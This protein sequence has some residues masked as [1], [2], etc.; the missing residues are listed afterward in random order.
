MDIIEYCEELLENIN[1]DS[2]DSNNNNVSLSNGHASLVDDVSSMF[3]DKT[4]VSAPVT[5]SREEVK[6]SLGEKYH[7]IVQLVQDR[8]ESQLGTSVDPNHDVIIAKRIIYNECGSLIGASIS[9]NMAACV[10]ESFTWKP[11]LIDA[12][13]L[14]KELDYLVATYKIDKVEIEKYE[15]EKNDKY[16]KWITGYK[17]KY[18]TFWLNQ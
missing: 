11:R 5:K 2:S 14:H 3:E 13:V 1:D 16:T 9:S 17:S 10:T 15:E 6:G 12:D 18:P 4:K 8:I 7:K